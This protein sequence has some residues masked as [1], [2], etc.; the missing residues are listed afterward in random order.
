MRRQWGAAA[1]AVVLTVMAGC[2]QRDDVGVRYALERQLWHAQL[3][4]RRINIAFL[5]A[6]QRD[7][8]AAIASFEQIVAADP[9]VQGVP[10]GWHAGEVTRVRR[11]VMVSKIAL[12]NLY[13]FAEHYY[14]AGDAY[15]RALEEDLSLDKELDVR[16]N[17]ARSLYLAGEEEPL[18]QQC[19]SIFGEI[20]DS[21][22][23]WS[24]GFQIKEVFLRLFENLYASVR[25]STPS[26]YRLWTS[27]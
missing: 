18:E 14:Q 2:G 1:I 8:T 4:E 24:G 27:R 26:P 6:S 22:D 19:A 25:K 15:A 16:L 21:E 5:H 12:A 10:V 17:L 23:F 3:H 13:F 9:F 20:V 7:L 11:I